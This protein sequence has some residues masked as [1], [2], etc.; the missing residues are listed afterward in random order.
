MKVTSS[1]MDL[2]ISNP[3]LQNLI[4]DAD[5]ALKL[6]KI[7][8]S[9]ISD[10]KGPLEGPTWDAIRSQMEAYVSLLDSRIN[11]AK[12]LYKAM[13][14]ANEVMDTWLSPDSEIDDSLLPELEAQAARLRSEIEA[15]LS[16]D[17]DASGPM[18]Q[19]AAVEAKIAKIKQLAPTDEAAYSHL[20]GSIANNE[21]FALRVS[22]FTPS[23]VI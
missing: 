22:S 20:N 14:D 12:E 4:T 5:E 17:L 23:T 6:R 19:L 21:A 15:L 9:F 7:I 16:E 1:D 10:S 8:A 11:N 18:S 13:G 2:A 3:V